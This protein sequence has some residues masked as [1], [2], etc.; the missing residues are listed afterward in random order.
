LLNGVT[1]V[2]VE[3]RIK[4][5]LSIAKSLSVLRLGRI[6]HSDRPEIGRESRQL[7]ELLYGA[8]QSAAPSIG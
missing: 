7:G 8:G 5:A 1:V 2:L 3:Q 6:V 4:T